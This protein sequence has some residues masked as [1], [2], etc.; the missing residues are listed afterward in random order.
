VSNED[1]KIRAKQA[2]CR[3]AIKL[4]GLESPTSQSEFTD[5]RNIEADHHSSSFIEVHDFNK[6]VAKVGKDKMKERRLDVNEPLNVKLQKFKQPFRQ[7]VKEMKKSTTV[8][9]NCFWKNLRHLPQNHSRCSSCSRSS[10]SSPRHCGKTFLCSENNKIRSHSFNM[11]EE[12]A[13]ATLF[14]ETYS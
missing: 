10:S 1:Q 7:A 11:K 14:I 3:L 12:I 8:R 5:Q 4:K 13:D 6:Y 2:L 9:E